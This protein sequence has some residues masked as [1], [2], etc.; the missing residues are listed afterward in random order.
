MLITQLSNV[1]RV[2]AFQNCGL[3]SP[4]N[5]THVAATNPANSNTLDHG[6]RHYNAPPTELR[7]RR[8]LPSQ[9]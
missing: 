9:T 1:C 7:Q 6:V 8:H 4:I 5:R 3:A 2:P